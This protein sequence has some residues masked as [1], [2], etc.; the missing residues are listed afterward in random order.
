MQG[1]AGCATCRAWLGVLHAGPGWVCYMQG[2]AGCATCRDSSDN[3]HQ[4]TLCAHTAAVK[5]MSEVVS[6]GWHFT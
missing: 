5:A 1:L 6:G 4:N 3:S 2:L